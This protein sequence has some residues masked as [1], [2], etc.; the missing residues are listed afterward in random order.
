MAGAI[1]LASSRNGEPGRCTRVV[2]ALGAKW[3]G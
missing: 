1:D 2:A 3:S